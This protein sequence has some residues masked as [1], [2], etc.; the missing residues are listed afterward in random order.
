MTKDSTNS[1][2]NDNRSTVVLIDNKVYELIPSETWT[3]EKLYDEPP[4]TRPHARTL[5]PIPVRTR[6][7]QEEL[8]K[9]HL[10]LHKL[11]ERIPKGRST[12]LAKAKEALHDGKGVPEQIQ[13]LL[14]QKEKSTKAG[15]IKEAKRIRKALRALD[16]KR[17]VNQEN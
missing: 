6:E 5:A 3:W 1:F 16:Y 11:C 9:Q 10:Q 4:T 8:N 15:D 7:E 12:P 13:A 17:Y 2:H 14:K